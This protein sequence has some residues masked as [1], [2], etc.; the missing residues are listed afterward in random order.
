MTLARYRWLLPAGHTAIDL[1]VL[2]IWLSQLTVA[3][4]RKKNTQTPSPA[5]TT[6]ANFQ[7]DGPAVGWSVRSCWDCEDPR[8]VL[9][10]SGVLPVGIISASL[11][12]QASRPTRQEPWD[13]IWF[14]IHEALAI[15]F[16]FL[17]GMW[18]D[19]ERSRLGRSMR[20]YLAA[21]GSLAPGLL[22]LGIPRLAT[23]LQIFFWLGLVC[24]AAVRSLLW[25]LR[26]AW[27][28]RIAIDPTG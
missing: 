18:L 8:F 14:M 23:M 27:G 1:V 28:R 20:I 15:P 5:S 17:L 24:Y 13:S 26:V 12:P 21:R 10:S 22:A 7:E 16:W 6:L 4:Y 2:T 11:R 19:V 3:S 9:L 25:L